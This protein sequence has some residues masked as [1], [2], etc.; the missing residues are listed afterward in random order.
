MPRAHD[1]N[2]SVGTSLPDPARL[3][4]RSRKIG[5]VYVSDGYNLEAS[6]SVKI[7]G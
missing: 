1:L 6:S 3:L 7:H 5:K 2:I 4:V